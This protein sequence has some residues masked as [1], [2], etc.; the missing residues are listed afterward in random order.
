LGPTFGKGP[1]AWKVTCTVV[2]LL[3]AGATILSV[4]HKQQA[5]PVRLGNASACVLKL[6]ALEMDMT[7]GSCDVA[8]VAKEYQ[9][10]TVNHLEFVT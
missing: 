6:R 10:L 1:P 3:T 4:I 9:E 7:L 5:V 2:A 8:Q